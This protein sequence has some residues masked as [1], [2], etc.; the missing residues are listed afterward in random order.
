MSHA[1]PAYDEAIARLGGAL[2]FGINPSLDGI[3]ALTDALGRPQDAF[4]SIQVT[5]TN[6]KTSATRVAAAA[7]VANGYRTG[8]Y[9]SPHLVS[10]T[11]R[12]EVDGQPMRRSSF[13]KYGAPPPHYD[14]RIRSPLLWLP[15]LDMY[16]GYGLQGP[17]SFLG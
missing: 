9:T 3:R 17:Y 10:Y 4:K 11:E 7:L 6:G 14:Q 8:L 15:C 12:V 13:N 5:G 2:R 1:T 16:G